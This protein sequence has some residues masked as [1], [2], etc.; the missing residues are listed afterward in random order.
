[1]ADPAEM[2]V[3]ELAVGRIKDYLQLPAPYRTEEDMANA[4]GL[5]CNWERKLTKNHVSVF[6]SDVKG[7]AWRALKTVGGILLFCPKAMS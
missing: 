3:V 6:S 1:M 2:A 7:H 4:A 5:I